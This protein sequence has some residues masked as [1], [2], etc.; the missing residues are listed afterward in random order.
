MDGYSISA[1]WYVI[2][3]G[4]LVLKTSTVPP[5]SVDRKMNFMDLFPDA[6]QFL[7]SSSVLLKIVMHSLGPA[8]AGQ[9]MKY[10]GFFQP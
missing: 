9:P 10:L 4:E 3:F 2:L 1:M 7:A 8:Q 6:L 5:P